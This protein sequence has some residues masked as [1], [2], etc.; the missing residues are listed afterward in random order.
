MVERDDDAAGTQVTMG[1]DKTSET[2]AGAPLA[3]RLRW[4]WP[5]LRTLLLIAAPVI[6]L[7]VMARVFYRREG[8]NN[9]LGFAD[10][11]VFF[12]RHAGVEHLAVSDVRFDGPFSYYLARD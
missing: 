2:G 6:V 9:T 3:T 10:L 5:L 7:L 11:R 12:A 8:D 1:R 4:L